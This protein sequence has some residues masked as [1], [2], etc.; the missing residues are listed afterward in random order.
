MNNKNTSNLSIDLDKINNTVSD[1]EYNKQKMYEYNKLFNEGVDFFNK[2]DLTGVPYRICNMW[3]DKIPILDGPIKY[4]EIGVFCGL[5][6]ISVACSYGNHKDSEIHCIDPWIDHDTYVEYKGEMSKIYATFMRNVL[7][8][9]ELDKFYI[10]RGFSSDEVLKLKDDY[11]DMIYI[12]GNHNPCN[13]LEDAILS[14]KKLKL[15]GYMIFDDYGWGDTSIGIHSFINSYGKS[16][17]I[18]LV[19]ID[20]FQCIVKKI[21]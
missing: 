9:G 14:Y 6:A 17:C 8:S 19:S 18:E 12:D 2:K 1:D 5:N 4:L 15:G 7:V 3:Y 11:F 20:R 13:V 16:N 21:K 10:H